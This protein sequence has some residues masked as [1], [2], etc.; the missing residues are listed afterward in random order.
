MSILGGVFQMGAAEEQGN[1][2]ERPQRQVTIE[3]E[4]IRLLKLSGKLS[5]NEYSGSLLS[6]FF[7]ILFN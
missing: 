4:S 3:P 1:A 2:S 5:Q 7:Y 6:Q